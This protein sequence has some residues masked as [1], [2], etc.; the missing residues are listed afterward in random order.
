MQMRAIADIP[1]SAIGLGGASWSLSDHPAF[2]ATGP[3]DDDRMI[4]TIH[5]ALDA[6]VNWIDTARAYTSFTHPGHSEATVARA[7]A[8]HPAGRDALVVTK[9]GHYRDGDV[10]PI[11]ARSETIRSHCELS[12]RLLGVERLDVYLLHW[13]DPD[14][15]IAEAMA[16]FVELREEGAIRQVGLSNVTVAQLEE[17]AAIVP[18]VCVENRFS[19]F[20]QADREM[21]GYCADRGI[22]YLAYSPLGAGSQSL[23]AAFPGAAALAR[24]KWV[25]IHRLALAWL[26]TLSPMIVP[27]CGAS[28]PETI[29][30]AALAS[31]VEPSEEELREL[32]FSHS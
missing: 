13:P 7:L 32:D 1:V 24:E 31:E 14:V 30:D 18:I 25:S 17:A 12:R 11:D 6:G 29:R 15:P 16:A 21:L 22:A 5:A 2:G 26:L 23:D 19:V 8:T 27:V 9:G 3:P 28:R 20:D 10:F 4:Q